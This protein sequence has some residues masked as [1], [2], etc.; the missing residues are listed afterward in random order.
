MK[1]IC[2]L[3]VFAFLLTSVTVF[4]QKQ[5]Y[6]GIGGTGMT[7]GFMNQNNY[8]LED[9]NWK[10][11]F[12]GS[13]NANIGFDFN[14]H[15]GLKLEIGYNPIGQKYDNSVHDT[16]VTRTIKQNYLQ[17]PLLFKYRSGGKSAK[18]F[19]AVGPQ[20]N[21]LMSATQTF[22]KNVLAYDTLVTN[23]AGKKEKISEGTITSRYTSINIMARLD[24]GVEILIIKNL[25]LDLALSFA[26]GLTDMNATDWRMKD[27]TKK[28]NA[29]HNAYGGINIGLNYVLPL[30]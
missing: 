12:G 26:Y 29:G 18:F 30:K 4:A 8:G 10:A 11:T 24:L 2:S 14:S 20:L 19:L 1:K 17:I 27:I 23:L 25:S 9:M 7:T 16:T 6:F 21:Y 15:I 22:D 5:L 13:F 3:I 28:Y